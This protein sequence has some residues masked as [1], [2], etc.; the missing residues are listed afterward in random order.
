MT[1][2]TLPCATLLPP[3]LAVV[4]WRPYPKGVPR[5]SVMLTT[6]DDAGDLNALLTQLRHQSGF[7]NAVVEALELNKSSFVT[8]GPELVRDTDDDDLA[9]WVDERR[10]FAH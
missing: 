9:A 1:H 5:A 6:S 8:L 10:A 4:Y 2:A 7:P 3:R